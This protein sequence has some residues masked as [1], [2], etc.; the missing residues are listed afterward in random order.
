LTGFESYQMYLGIKTHFT[1]EKYDYFKFNGKTKAKLESFEKR[2]DRYFFKKLSLKYNGDELKN[3]YVSNFIK[4][5]FWIGTLAKTGETNYIEWKKKIESIS[6]FFEQDVDCLLESVDKFDDL[7]TCPNN[8][9]PVLLK[10]YLSNKISL[11]T[12]TVFN[13]KLSFVKQF[14][15][16]IKETVVWPGIKLKIEKYFPFLD[17]NYT[18][19][20]F[21]LRR[22][23]LG[24][25]PQN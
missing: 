7:F 11:E 1:N 24:L 21:V 23:V 14:D 15:I 8:Q 17:I 9:H 13:V 22:K 20:N 10:Y 3:F 19:L 4:D 16:D 18:K 5:D 2:N 6:Y 25:T 12:L